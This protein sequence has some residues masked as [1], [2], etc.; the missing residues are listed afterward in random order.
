VKPNPFAGVRVR[1]RGPVVIHGRS[2][3]LTLTSPLS[4]HGSLTVDARITSSGRTRTL[5]L[6]S[7][8]FVISARHVTVVTLGVP[9]GR[10]AFLRTHPRAL[11]AFTMRSVSATGLDATVA[12]TAHFRWQR[13]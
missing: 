3:E 2:L 13:R 10:L 4:A 11:L 7:T 8:R 9:G 6:G 12:S 5:R 1:Q